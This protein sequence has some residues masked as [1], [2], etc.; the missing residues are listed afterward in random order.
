MRQATK[1]FLR[2]LLIVVMV[3]VVFGGTLTWYYLFLEIPTH[4]ASAEDNFKYGSLGNEQTDGIPYWL[5]LVLPRMFPDKV[6]GL[7]GYA[8]F[9]LVWE[10]GKELPVGFSKKTIGF[11]RVAINCA[12]CHTATYRTRPGDKPIIVAGGPSHQ[13]DPQSYVRFLYACAS[14]ARFNPDNIMTEINRVYK[15]SAVERLLY[16]YVLIPQTKEALL[17]QKGQFAW[18]DQ[19]PDWGRGRIDP[20]NPIKFGIL[21]Q[22]QD[23]TVGNADMVS[24]WNQKLRQGKSLHWDGLNTS[25]DEVTISSAIGD[26]ATYKNIEREN[27]K[28]MQD[29]IRDLPAPRYPYAIDQQLAD[30]GSKIF[31]KSCASCHAPGGA[32]TG[33]VV[34]VEEVGTDRHRLDMWTRGAADAY[35]NYEPGYHWGFKSF[36]KTNGYVSPPLDGVWLRAPYLHNGAVPSLAELLM[37]PDQ[38]PKVFWRGFDVYDQERVGFVSSGAEAEKYFRFDTSAVGN[39]NGGHL[40]GTDLPPED[41]K[42]LIE[43][44]KT[45]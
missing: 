27:L 24:L 6:P 14:D 5:W 22:Q 40:W 38:R 21:K 10:E 34:P 11:D 33:Q 42:A 13:F 19:R 29:W 3:L 43:F 31:E 32:T 16:R 4:Y 36:R 28:R 44:L 18:M 37:P 9:G 8:S 7:G 15:L 41:K 26:G 39:S 35:N 2:V 1:K 30:A 25:E 17:K 12:F 23:D 45:Q 20:F